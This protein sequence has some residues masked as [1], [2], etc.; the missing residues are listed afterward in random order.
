VEVGEG[1]FRQ[2]EG[3]GLDGVVP[4]AEAKVEPSKLRLVVLGPGG[5]EQTRGRGLI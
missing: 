2:L 5:Q 3:T 4:L 1:S